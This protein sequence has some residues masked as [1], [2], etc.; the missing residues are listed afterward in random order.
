M[1]FSEWLKL[2]ETGTST[3]DV[4]HVPTRLFGGDKVFRRI[5]ANIK[6]FGLGGPI[7]TMRFSEK[8]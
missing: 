2:Q 6:K 5:F 4:S 1:K 8:K 7:H 3:A